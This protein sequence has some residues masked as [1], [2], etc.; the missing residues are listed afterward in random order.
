MALLNTTCPR[1]GTPHARKLSV[2]YSEGLTVSHGTAQS[3]GK[4]NTIGGQKITTSGTTFSTQQTDASKRAAPPFVP[5]LVSEGSKAQT[6]AM[7][8]GFAIITIV[9]F[10]M[11]FSGVSF[12]KVIGSFLVASIILIV[13]NGSTDTKPTEEEIQKHQNTFKREYAAYEEWERMFSC[14]SCGSKFLPVECENEASIA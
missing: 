10:I 11:M 8:V 1:C 4:L 2:I 7:Y 9:I 13:I 5:V 6:R 14:T 3:V 12:L